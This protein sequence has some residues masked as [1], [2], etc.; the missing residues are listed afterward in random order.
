MIAATLLAVRAAA[1]VA[2][3][4]TGTLLRLTARTLL[5]VAPRR[6]HQP[7]DPCPCICCSTRVALEATGR[8][9]TPWCDCADYPPHQRCD[10]LPCHQQH[11]PCQ[12][13]P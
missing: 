5:P 13:L 6:P 4:T 7:L 12:A 11:T 2:G 10:C 3:W 1:Y 8:T 9:E